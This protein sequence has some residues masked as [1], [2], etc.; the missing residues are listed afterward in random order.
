LPR[1]AGVG[2]RAAAADGAAE[3]G[4]HHQLIGLFQEGVAAAIME[5]LGVQ[6][7]AVRWAGRELSAIPASSP[8]R[9]DV[10]RPGL[11]S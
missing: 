6:A 8:V 2:S 7:T 11:W 4:T 3:I 5:R 10:H 1:N 9:A